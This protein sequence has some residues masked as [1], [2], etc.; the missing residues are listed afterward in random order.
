MDIDV[1]LC[2]ISSS[3]FI[4]RLPKLLTL[5]LIQKF[6]LSKFQNICIFILMFLLKHLIASDSVI[7][8]CILI[9]IISMTKLLNADWRRGVQLFR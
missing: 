8:S 3:V 7:R 9:H 4:F 5:G 1:I 6:I 2:I